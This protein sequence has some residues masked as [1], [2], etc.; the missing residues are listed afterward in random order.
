MNYNNYKLLG[1]EL[2]LFMVRIFYNM[3]NNTYFMSVIIFRDCLMII[4]NMYYNL[5]IIFMSL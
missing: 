1:E 5:K 2:L 3:F 4:E